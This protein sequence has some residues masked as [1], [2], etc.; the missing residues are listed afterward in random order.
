MKHILQMLKLKEQEL[1]RV[2]GEIDALRVVASLFTEQAA[3]NISEQ[4]SQSGENAPRAAANPQPVCAN[5]PRAASPPTLEPLS[6]APPVMPAAAPPAM[7]TAA[8]SAYSNGGMKR[9]P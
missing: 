4:A 6:P 2:Q 7:A 8:P 1:A 9:F 3:R 5:P